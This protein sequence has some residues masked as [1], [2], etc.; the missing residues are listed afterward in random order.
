M[1]GMS[2]VSREDEVDVDVT[3]EDQKKI[4][5]F[6][7]MNQRMLEL[8]DE[9]KDKKE[10]V[11]KCSDA[12]TEIYIADDIKCVLGEAFVAIETDAAEEFIDQ[13][14]ESL[15]AEIDTMEKE[16]EDI[17]KRMKEFKGQLYAKFGKSIY[18]ENE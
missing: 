13:R 7:R 14:K 4:C 15:E 9:I 8:V 10:E 18:L 2:T 17:Q 12:S 5:T 11:E 1:Q 16:L 6:G 3:W